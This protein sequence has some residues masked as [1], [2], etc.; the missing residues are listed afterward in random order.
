MCNPI[1]SRKTIHKQSAFYVLIGN[2]ETKYWSSLTNIHLALLCRYSAVKEVGYRKNSS[3]THCWYQISGIRKSRNWDWGIYGSVVVTSSADNPTSYA[4]VGLST[5]FSS[6]RVCRQCMVTKLTLP[7]VHCETKCTLRTTENHMTAAW[8]R[9]MVGR[10][11][12]SGG[13]CFD[14]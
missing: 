4:V 6:G 7:D 10:L 13:P 2:I 12:R 3:A 5:C 1:G 14:C 9:C 8:H 11:L